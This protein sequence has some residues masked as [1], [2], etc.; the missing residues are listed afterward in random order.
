MGFMP[1]NPAIYLA[2][3]AGAM[4]GMA[5]RGNPIVNP[6]YA[7]AMASAYAQAIDTVWDSLGFTAV[8][9]DSL[10]GASLVHWSARSPLSSDEAFDYTSYLGIA[11]DITELT[12]AG[13]TTVIAQG[14]D[15]NFY[16]APPVKTAFSYNTPSPLFLQPVIAGQ[17]LVRVMILII[18]PFN[19]PSAVCHLGVE[20]AP[21]E[22]FADGE[23]HLAVPATY[24]T[25]AMIPFTT[26]ETLRLAIS[27]GTSTQGAGILLYEVV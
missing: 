24:K 16:G 12:R 22:V 17:L 20:S 9:L 19:D 6:D 26:S 11:A 13:T 8:D 18:E 27:P 23:V 7:A 3:L 15:P 10:R 1:Q 25:A 5:A 21:S 4:D 14:I 2:A